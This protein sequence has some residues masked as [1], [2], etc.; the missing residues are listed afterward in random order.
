MQAAGL[1]LPAC[2]SA[3]CSSRVCLACLQQCPKPPHT[4]V[5]GLPVAVCKAAWHL[6][7][8]RVECSTVQPSN[9]NTRLT[10]MQKKSPH[11]CCSF[12]IILWEICTGAG[13]VGGIGKGRGEE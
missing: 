7:T 6:C 3:N 2:R 13:R 11:P 9:E 10:L 1:D 8:S 12:G 4:A 5:P